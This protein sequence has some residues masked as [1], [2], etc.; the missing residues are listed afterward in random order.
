MNSHNQVEN[1][2]LKRVRNI[3]IIWSRYLRC[4]DSQF[5]QRRILRKLYWEKILHSADWLLIQISVNIARATSLH[6]NGKLKMMMFCSTFKAKSE[7]TCNIFELLWQLIRVSR[8]AFI[9]SAVLSK[10]S[11]RDLGIQS[12]LSRNFSSCNI[13]SLSVLCLS[14][15]SMVSRWYLTYMFNHLS[16]FYSRKI[17]L[18]TYVSIFY[19]YLFSSLVWVL[20]KERS[21]LPTLYYRAPL[22]KI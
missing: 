8:F 17:Y 19:S 9:N 16:I 2:K 12:C 11:F 7:L 5:S 1:T 15:N 20:M 6:K 4:G 21:M 10:F 22:R 3:C 13:V 18:T 14:R